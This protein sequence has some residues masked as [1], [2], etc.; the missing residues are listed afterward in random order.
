MATD[1]VEFIKGLYAAF[2]RADIPPVLEAMD[3]KIEWNEA[4]GNPFHLGYPFIGSDQVVEHVFIRSATD[5]E[6]FEIHPDR[7]F[8]QG[9]TVVM[10]GRYHGKGTAT[11]KAL[12]AQVAHVWDLKDGKVVR[13]QQYA[14]TRHLAE[15]LGAAEG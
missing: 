1:N 8:G 7:F 5:F 9:D 15:V 11:G 2:A 4:E 10:Q 13:F 12:D 3:D 14:D 6:G